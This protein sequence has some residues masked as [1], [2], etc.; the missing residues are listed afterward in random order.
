VDLLKRPALEIDAELERFRGVGDPLADAAV[1]ELIA[2]GALRGRG[3][4][5]VGAAEAQARSGAK[6]CQ[7][8][9]EHAHAVPKWVSFPTMAVGARLGLR[10]AV[11]S[12][13]ALMLGSLMESYASAKGAKVLIR[14]GML[15]T[16]VVQ[17]LH[18]T[19]TFVLEIAAS[20]GPGPGTRAH[21]HVLRTRLV[22]G[23]VRHGMLKRADWDSAAWGH[24]VNQEDYAST[25]L[26][27]CHVYLRAMHRIGVA[28]TP[29]EEAGVH[30]LYRWVGHVM[31][32]APEL[33]SEDREE[34]QALYGH[35]TR[36]QLHPDA[37]S[38]ALAAALVSG[39]AFRKPFFLPSAALAEFTRQML[40]DA[41]ADA[42]GLSHSARWS[43]VR[44]ALPLL[45]S[46]QRQVERVP[47]TIAPME[48]LGER[49][50]RLVYERGLV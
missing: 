42:L 27:F 35:I 48:F 19:T 45:S 44:H 31:G 2:C 22:H 24:P 5:L 12:A 21:R 23:F 37:D 46:A 50:A 11:Q 34:E 36:R 20:R 18:D 28:V 47:L 4:D 7:A 17:R 9:L 16:Q 33:L 8:L 43:P 15:Q 39:L 32:V 40:G 14:S 49:L 26:A 10:T 29:E 38:R 25:L 13:M 3:G 41:L 1:A 30:H 6:A